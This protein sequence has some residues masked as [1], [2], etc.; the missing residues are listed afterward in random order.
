MNDQKKARK[1]SESFKFLNL[2]YRKLNNFQNY[3]LMYK[4]AIIRLQNVKYF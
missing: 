3:L 4:Y 1:H 2:R